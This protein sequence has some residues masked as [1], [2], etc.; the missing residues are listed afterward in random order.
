MPFATYFLSDWLLCHT[1]LG[2]CFLIAFAY[3]GSVATGF[4]RKSSLARQ[5]HRA[6]RVSISSTSSTPFSSNSKFSSATITSMSSKDVT[7]PPSATSDL[8][9]WHFAN[10]VHA[11]SMDGMSTKLRSMAI[12]RGKRSPRASKDC[13]G[14]LPRSKFRI[15]SAGSASILSSAFSVRSSET[16]TLAMPESAGR[17]LWPASLTARCAA[18]T[19]SLQALTSSRIWSQ[20]SLVTLVSASS[21]DSEA[22][23]SGVESWSF[24]PLTVGGSR[25]T[26]AGT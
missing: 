16:A 23:G 20:A 25:G 19:A 5:G 3:P 21:S 24:W 1:S 12:K 4:S 17:S 10:A 9:R 8:S 11:P 14:L 26:A 7:P 2:K 15:Q 22:Q 13:R 18:P 6:A